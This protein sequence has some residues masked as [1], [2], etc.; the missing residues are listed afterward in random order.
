MVVIEEK[1]VF[2]RIIGKV[3]ASTSA[4]TVDLVEKT[5][6]STAGCLKL[7][8]FVERGARARDWGVRIRTQLRRLV[9]LD[10]LGVI[11]LS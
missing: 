6:S 8:N 4:S 11:A 2:I 1:R 7:A 3:C 5:A 9:L 10:G